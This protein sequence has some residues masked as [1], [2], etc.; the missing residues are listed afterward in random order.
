[1][2]TF[3]TGR[4]TAVL[5]ERPGLQRVE[6][7]GEAAYVLTELTGPVA[8]DDEVVLNTTAVE[9]NL[10]S[11]GAHVVHWNL[12]RRE[13]SAPGPG[14][15]MKLRYTSLQADRGAAEEAGPVPGSLGG[16][17]VVVCGLHSQ[18]GVVAAAFKSAAPGA[19][20]AYVMTDGGALP[21]ALSD[22][23]A[24]ARRAGLIDLTVSAG[25]AFGGDFEA[26]H[27]ASGLAVARHLGLA[28]AA[29]VGM[30]PGVVGTGT[31]LGT[32]ALEVAPLLDLAIALDGRAVIALRISGADSRPRHRGLSHHS[33][34]ALGL[35]ARR[36]A[37]VV[38]LPEDLA[39]ELEVPVRQARLVRVPDMAR[40]LAEA[41]LV[42]TTMGR[43]PAQDPWFFAAAGA[44]GI[45]AAELLGSRAIS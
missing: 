5:S 28:D 38:P 27:P 31:T 43:G 10:G 21:L 13:W 11:G 3:R 30:G 26:V 6:V 32:T 8:T 37:V 16:M 2:P 14:E 29:V 41:G 18:V 15:V 9:R 23:V 4:V 20:L 22:L 33:L 35:V 42:V 36:D 45:V 25:H 24:D 17:P 1:M 39:A 34:T 19:R 12:A 40:V 44:A 7:D